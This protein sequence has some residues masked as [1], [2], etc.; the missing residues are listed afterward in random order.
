MGFRG[1]AGA[2]AHSLGIRAT[3]AVALRNERAAEA[4]IGPSLVN[5]RGRGRPVTGLAALEPLTASAV[6]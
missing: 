1:R 4:R 2:F 5:S 6:A 3:D